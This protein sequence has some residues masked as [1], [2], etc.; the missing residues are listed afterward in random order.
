MKK[1]SIVLIICCGFTQLQAQ[2]TNSYADYL[3]KQKNYKK[4]A[5]LEL[6]SINMQQKIP[7]AIVQPKPAQNNNMD[8]MPI[9]GNTGTFTFVENK[10]GFE[11]YTSS[12]DKMPV[13]KP[14]AGFES[15]MPVAGV[16]Q[17]YITTLKKQN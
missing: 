15:N 2:V 16:K 13:L 8:N 3:Q 4:I 10:N 7:L 5:G 11:I 17:G 14:D 12:V 6:P 9:V 1:I